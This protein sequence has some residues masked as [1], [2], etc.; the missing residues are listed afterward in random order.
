MFDDRWWMFLGAGV[1]TT[2]LLITLLNLARRRHQSS[3]PLIVGILALGFGFQSIGLYWRGLAVR[4]CPIGNPFEVLQYISWST[5]AV[6]FL[7]G[8]IF[9][10]S[11]LGVFA[12][13][14]AA[15]LSLLSIIVPAWD[16]EHAAN[17][18]GGNP[19][20]ES[21]A[22]IALFSY[23]VFGLLAATSAMY[24][25]QNHGLKQKQVQGIYAHLPSVNELDTVNQRLSFVG[26]SVFSLAMIIGSVF[27]MSEEANVSALKLGVTMC[28][29]WAYLVLAALRLTKRL[30]GKRFACSALVLFGFAL[31]TLGIVQKAP[32]PAPVDATVLPS[33]AHQE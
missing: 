5:M 30:R 3:A 18:F 20:I 13:I 28:L 19:W 16:Y 2:A 23:G 11:L 1:Y 29:W 15:V 22:A 7:A 27:W 24:L 14:V 10:M 9:R 25:L 4:S 8:S 31:I 33:S 21:H 12:A 6:Y 32:D 17:I 26:A